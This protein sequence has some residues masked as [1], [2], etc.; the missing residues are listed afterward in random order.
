M[1]IRVLVAYSMA[2]AGVQTTWDYV[3]SFKTMKADVE[4][5]HVTHEAICDADTNRYDAVINNYCARLNYPGSVSESYKNWLREFP[6]VKVLS[7]QD[8]YDRTDAIKSA[9][10]EFGFDI[11]LTCVPSAHLEYVYS[12]SEFPGV[13]FST[14]LTGYVPDCA[15]GLN[16]DPLPLSKRPV[17]VGYRGRNLGGR[18]GQ[19]AFEKFEIGRRMKEICV[20]QGI[21]HDIAMDEES[22]IYGSAWLEFVGSC[23]A[24]LGTES[25]SNIFDFSGSIE[26]EFLR[27]TEANGSPP[28]YAEFLP[29]VAHREHL[30]EMG[31]ISPRVF[32]CAL[33]RTPMILFRGRYSDLIQPGVHYIELEKDFSNVGEVL[34]GLDRLDQLQ[35][36]ADRAFEHLVASGRYSYPAFANKVEN[37]VRSVL[38]RRQAPSSRIEVKNSKRLGPGEEVLISRPTA[39]P[40]PRSGFDLQQH[41][42]EINQ[43]ADDLKSAAA[44]YIAGL[45]EL[46][47]RATDAKPPGSLEAV[48]LRNIARFR[49]DLLSFRSRFGSNNLSAGDFLST[50]EELA[51]E[52]ERARKEAESLRAERNNLSARFSVTYQDLAKAV[53]DARLFSAYRL[54]VNQL[55]DDLVSSAAAYITGLDELYSRVTDSHK[56]PDSLE[57]GLLADIARFR[58]HLL[59]FRSRFCANNPSAVEDSLNTFDELARE[60][61]RARKEAESLYAERNNLSGAYQE[62]ARAASSIAQTR[63]YRRVLA[64]YHEE[65]IELRLNADRESEVYMRASN[66]LKWRLNAA[67]RWFGIQSEDVSLMQRIDR[68][69]EQLSQSVGERALL[70]EDL[71][72]IDR[73]PVAKLAAAVER[74]RTRSQAAYRTAREMTEEYQAIVQKAGML[75]ARLP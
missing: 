20:A 46:R 17:L 27:L 11:V 12:R 34:A 36:M 44:A 15:S 49:E 13:C 9:V 47:S 7:V 38:S 61:E 33:M 59:G 18:Y 62:L 21:P 25:G 71:R 60:A 75:A 14:V 2:S 67:F 39:A 29:Q 41:R 35:A 57:A 56:P 50:F 52:A 68:L 26:E 31:Q 30:V 43:L 69:L 16:G 65:M 42:L 48:L 54:E 8:E 10:K 74:Y 32:E 1:T 53:E 28:S 6:G 51:R 19:L 63:E 72:S 66:A 5:L 37:L 58:G 73:I 4:Y 55:T 3:C 64:A 22:R 24:M 23:R 40:S 70:V 45:D